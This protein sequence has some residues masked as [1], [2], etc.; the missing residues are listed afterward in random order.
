[1][2]KIQFISS[3][4]KLHEYNF[5]RVVLPNTPIDVYSDTGYFNYANSEV[6]TYY[7]KNNIKVFTANSFNKIKPRFLRV[8]FNLFSAIKTII[9]S[10]NK[11]Y[12]YCFVHY[13]S[14]RRAILSLFVPKRTKIILIGYGSDVLRRK[15]L[16]DFFFKK[17]LKRSHLIIL[18]SMNMVSRFRDFYGHDYVEKMK[19]IQFPCASFDRL[20]SYITTHS[21]DEALRRFGFPSNK[22]I[23]VCGHTA[24]REEQF[25]RIIDAI[26]RAPKKQ[27]EKYFFVFFMTYGSGDYVKYREEIRC[28]LSN[29]NFSSM[30]LEDYL[31][32]DTMCLLHLVSDIHITAIKTD[33]LSLF[34][35]E[36]MF[37]G[38][39]VLYGSWLNYEEFEQDNYNA[40]S[41]ADFN[42]LTGLLS[43]NKKLVKTAPINKLRNKISLLNSNTEIHKKWTDIL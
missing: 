42:E 15:S 10:Q 34:M 3:Y 29:S 20:N 1:M 26:E 16:K 31:D 12:D 8:V 39:L 23:V 36:E 17:M 38:A 5:I 30:I 21:R 19:Y 9:K 25:E 18:N 40:I 22:K 37:A 2:K 6:E 35:L 24:T 41:F 32:Y 13:L 7:Q 14:T 43:D 28:K 27:I 33:A 4:G 11:K